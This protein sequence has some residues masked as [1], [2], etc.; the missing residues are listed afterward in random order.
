MGWFLIWGVGV[1]KSL[2]WS[3]QNDQRV[4]ILKKIFCDKVYFYPPP[5]SCG[6]GG[7]IRVNFFWVGLIWWDLKKKH[8]LVGWGEGG[9]QV[10]SLPNYFVTPNLSWAVT[11]LLEGT[12][13]CY[14]LPLNMLFLPLLNLPLLTICL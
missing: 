5:A 7:G 8:F 12:R 6:G 11:I 1:K 3:V 13:F 9:R 4:K 10:K 14:L 2:G